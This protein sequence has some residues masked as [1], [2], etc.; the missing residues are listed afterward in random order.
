M[1]RMENSHMI[2]FLAK[3]Y[4]SPENYMYNGRAG[5]R[6]VKGNLSEADGSRGGNVERTN[7]R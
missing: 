4:I 6:Q 2:A 1:T 5:Q 7:F 3:P